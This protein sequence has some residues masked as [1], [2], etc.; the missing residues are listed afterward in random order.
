[1]WLCRPPKT[2]SITRSG[3]LVNKYST[4]HC[5]KA[6]PGEAPR[7]RRAMTDN[8]F[9]VIYARGLPRSAGQAH[10]PGRSVPWRGSSSRL[11]ADHVQERLALLFLDDAQ[12]AP[13]GLG[14][15]RGVFDALAVAA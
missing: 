9:Y 11:L 7:A 8:R 5:D 2:H 6:P 15:L 4:P 13:E 14:E 1:M 12:R 10:A 3:S